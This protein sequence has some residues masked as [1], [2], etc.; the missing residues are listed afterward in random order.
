VGRQP[1]EIIA[2]GFDMTPGTLVG[3]KEGYITAAIDSQQYLAGFYGVLVLYHY[4]L[5]GFLPTVK[6][7]G[8]LIDSPEKIK[9]IE[10]LSKDYIR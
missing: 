2:G 7:G 1:G 8:F 4:K 6:T 10:A 3:L 9:Q 5:Y